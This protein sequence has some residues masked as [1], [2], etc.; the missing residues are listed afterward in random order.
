[1]C[2]YLKLF[3]ILCQ[4]RKIKHEIYLFRKQ[5][6]FFFKI[7]KLHHFNTSEKNTE[8]SDSTDPEKVVTSIRNYAVCPQVFEFSI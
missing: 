4:R 6:S 5:Y 7:H 1:M 2:M 3:H 8:F